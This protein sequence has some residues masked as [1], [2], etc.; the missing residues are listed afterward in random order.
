[1]PL[2]KLSFRPG[3]TKESTTYANE[4]GFYDSNWVR[5]RYGYPEKI[6][7]WQNLSFNNTF[8]GVCRSIWSWV[9]HANEKLLGIGTS[10]KYYIENGGTYNDITPVRAGPTT[11]GATPITTVNGSRLVTVTA[12]GHGASTGTFVRLTSTTPVGGLTISGEYEIITVPTGNSFTIAAATEATSSTSGGGTVTVTYDINAGSSTFTTIVGGWSAGGWGENGWGEGVGVAGTTPLRIWSQASYGEDLLLAPRGGTIYYWDVDTVAYTR[13]S[14]L[15]TRASGLGKVITTATS[16]GIGST[17]T[18]ADTT[19][20]D[21]GA[22]ILSGTNVTTGTTVTAINFLTKVL[23]L[24][25]P[26]AGAASGNYTFSFVGS[27]VPYQTEAIFM[28][29]VS[30]FA[31]CLGANPYSP[32]VFNTDYNPMLVRWSEQDNCYEWVSTPTNQAGEKDLSVGSYLVCAQNTRQEVLIWSDAALYSMQYIGPPYAFNFTLLSDNISIASPNAVAGAGN[33]SYW[34]G[35]DKFY[36]Y[37]GRVDT[38]QCPLWGHVFRDINKDQLFQV[39]AG[40]NEGFNEVWWFYPSADSN[41]ANKYVVFNY[42]ENAWYHGDINRTAW[43]DSSLRSYPMGVFSAQNTYLSTA[44][45]SSTTDIPVLNLD[46][47]PTSGTVII[48]GEEITYTGRTEN[49][50]TGC[51]RGANTTTAAAHIAYSQVEYATP[52][53][54]MYHEL[55]T[56]DLSTAVPSPISA[57]VTSG[58]FDIGD[59]HQFGFV[60]RMLPDLTF[61]G[62]TLAAPANPSITLALEARTNSGT[63]Y[64]STAFPTVNRTYEIPVEQYT[65]QVYTRIRGRQMRFTISSNTLGVAW[66]LGQVRADIRPDGRSV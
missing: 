24:S 42:L 63:N 35:T 60:W 27:A 37:S 8:S 11:L 7:G 25:A 58:D 4:G 49:R 29:D 19:D 30:K 32:G 1:M 36:T 59:G 10:Q 54:V 41:V 23:T 21:I 16:A 28:S 51:T 57:Y 44:V 6:G 26:T 56:D 38:L 18:V 20:I 17:I 9:T 45:D 65:G 3:I 46:S 50:L 64:S 52:N 12:A 61:N 5:F 43:L 39:T 53:Q 31:I 62:T 48:D 55:G 2:T 40:T 66:Q 15:S 13:A 34:M 22:A 47:Y 14:L 33:V